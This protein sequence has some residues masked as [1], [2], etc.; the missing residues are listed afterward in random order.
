MGYTDVSYTAQKDKLHLKL[1]EKTGIEI[2]SHKDIIMPAI[3]GILI[4]SKKSIGIYAGGNI[5][6]ANAT[7]GG[8]IFM[9]CMDE[10]T[11]ILDRN[12]FEEGYRKITLPRLAPPLAMNT[13]VEQAKA[14]PKEKKNWWKAGLKVLGAIAVVAAVASITVATG[15]LAGPVFAAV[16]AGFIV[17]AAIGVGVTATVGVIKGTNSSWEDYLENAINWGCG[18]AISGAVFAVAGVSLKGL[19]FLQGLGQTAGLG[20]VSGALVNHTDQ[21]VDYFVDGTPVSVSKLALA[22]AEGA[23]VSGVLYTVGY[24]VSKIYQ[25]VKGKASAKKAV[26]QKAVVEEPLA[27][28][29]VDN[30][31]G[32]GESK[33]VSK[34]AGEGAV[35]T[36]RL[37]TFKGDEAVIHFDKHGKEIMD[38]LGNNSYNLKQYVQDANYIIKNGEYVPEINGYVTLMGGKGSAK[39]GFV[40]LD[41]AT[42]KI[43]TF[44]LKTAGEL[45]K[46]APSLGISK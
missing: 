33:S 9:D 31:T 46:K 3:K 42:G 23:V 39:Y 21:M 17:G 32:G 2:K 45:A 38:S 43:T 4:E 22:T 10:N 44:H 12:I 18:G 20:G 25:G 35:K 24:G 41:R 29:G 40:G 5:R 8:G 28:K 11:H 14:K 36:E 7:T 6:L 16:G 19:T 37:I 27:N 34:I 13:Y 26:P 15:G 30:N 1:D